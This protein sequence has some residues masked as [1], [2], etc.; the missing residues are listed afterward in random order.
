MKIRRW[1]PNI[2]TVL[3]AALL[4]V[5]QQAWASPLMARLASP[6]ATSK[7]SIA[8]QGY[9]T[10][11]AGAAVNETLE[12]V[13]KL[14]SVESGGAPLWSEIQPSVVVADGVF[15][16][17]LGSATPISADMIATNIDLWLG[18]AVGS[19][20]E[21]APRDK[22]A[23]A[24][25]AMMADVPDGSITQYKLQ[26]NSV[27]ST[28]IM[29]GEVTSNDVGFNYAGASAKGGAAADVAC[30][31]CVNSTDIQDGQVASADVGFNYAAGST[32]GGAATDLSCTNCVSNGEIVDGQVTN[33]D[34]A[35]NSVTST[36]IADGQV[37]NNDVGFNYAG[38]SSKGGP[39][40]DVSCS[41]C[42]GSGDI[43]NGAVTQAK[44][45]GIRTYVGE[46]MISVDG[47]GEGCSTFSLPSGRFT[48]TPNVFVSRR[49]I[50]T[51]EDHGGYA[52]TRFIET[53][54]RSTTSVRICVHDDLIVNGNIGIAYFVVQ[55]D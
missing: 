2:I 49:S 20:E 45:S 38:S 26:E 12:M 35:N 50:G 34:L 30:S 40:S 23:S 10:D 5:T 52:Q 15:S 28:K 27:T 42:V 21:M 29:D 41:T 33:P 14:Y 53:T 36:K 24:P 51:W 17:L 13:F 8:Y 54:V 32:K 46:G 22:I 19:D 43:A 18:V 55:S 48:T 25:Y 16:V 6:T 47:N 1:I 44:L 4:V 31:G 39:A 3:L 37:G 11:S 9:L 7:T